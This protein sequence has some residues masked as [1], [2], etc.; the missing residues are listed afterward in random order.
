MPFLVPLLHMK[1]PQDEPNFL[2]HVPFRSCLYHLES[3]NPTLSAECEKGE[4]FSLSQYGLVT[5][6]FECGPNKQ[7][8]LIV[9]DGIC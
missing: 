5:K 7:V 1:Y 6:M 4:N 9:K 2:D 3:F 8:L